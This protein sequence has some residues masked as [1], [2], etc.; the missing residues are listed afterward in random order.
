MKN[1]NQPDTLQLEI[2]DYS[3]EYEQYLKEKEK[4]LKNEDDNSG[5][6]V[7]IIDI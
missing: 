6:T 5:G 4:E 7:I 2:P 1:H 3:H